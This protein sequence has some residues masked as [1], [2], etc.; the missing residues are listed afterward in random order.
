MPADALLSHGVKYILKVGGSVDLN[1]QVIK[2]NH[3][4]IVI[5][6][7]EFCIPPM[8]Q[9]GEINTIEGFITN[10]AERIQEGQE[11][12]KKIDPETTKKIQ[13]VIDRLFG[14][15]RGEEMFT[16]ELEDPSGHSYLENPAAPADDPSAEVTFF[17]RTKE[18]TRDMGYLVEGDE[19]EPDEKESSAEAFNGIEV[20]EFVKSK[21]DTYFDVT[22]QAASFP[23][24]CHSC[25]CQSE[26]RMCTTNIPHFKDVVIMVS[27]CDNCGYRDSEVKPG[28]GI[29]EKGKRMTLKY[30][31]I[32][33]FSRDLLKS[34]STAIS[35]PEIELELGSGSLGGKFTTVQGL[36]ED[37]YDLIMRTNAFAIG[38]SAEEKS[39]DRMEEFLKRLNQI[40]SGEVP[41]TLIL[42]DPLGN[43]FIA[44][45]ERGKL[46]EQLSVEE[47][48]RSFEQNEEFGLNDMQTEGYE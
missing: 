14:M 19:D 1:R 37:I 38:D 21:L 24:L 12:R 4:S 7:L 35:I 3:G 22:S 18:Q 10:A 6:E 41:F 36:L 29:S 43:V 39:S 20:S 40:R 47:Y 42:D 45:T 32:D 34:D 26:V 46:D 5:K 44:S 8:T 31:N 27:Q 16:F 33:D 25:H 15:A 30:K 28:G 11:E 17:E 13:A 2:S 48:E 9:K 23:G